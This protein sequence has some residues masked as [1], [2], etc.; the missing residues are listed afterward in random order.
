MR[1]EVPQFIDVEDKI[2]GPLTLKQFVYVAG[3]A[4]GIALA[5]F[6]LPFIVFII[7]VPILASL[8]AGL[9]F[10]PV[11][12]RPMSLFLEAIVMYTSRSKLYL[13]RKQTRTPTPDTDT[14]SES[15]KTYTPPAS[16]N[17]ERWHAGDAT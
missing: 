1:F 15:K 7:V 5:Y 12:D 4:G 8:S 13:W 11:N 9:A 14:E 6:L 17:T 16:K 10:L 2:F 3:G